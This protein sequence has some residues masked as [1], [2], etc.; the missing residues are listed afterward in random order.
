MSERS[1][2]ATAYA[3]LGL[4]SLK[5][6]QPLS[7]DEPGIGARPAGGLGFLA[8]FCISATQFDI[9][10]FDEPFY[11][12][13]HHLVRLGRSRVGHTL[14]A[15][16]RQGATAAAARL[17]KFCHTQG[18]SLSIGDTHG[19]HVLE[20]ALHDFDN[21]YGS[22]CL[23]GAVAVF[24]ALPR[25]VV[26]KRSNNP[27]LNLV[28]R[29]AID[30]R[31][32]PSIAWLL[33]VPSKLPAPLRA[34]CTAGTK[35]KRAPSLPKLVEIACSENHVALIEACIAQ[36]CFADSAS[37]CKALQQAIQSASPQVAEA[38]LAHGAFH[39]WPFPLTSRQLQDVFAAAAHKSLKSN[40]QYQHIC[41][42]LKALPLQAAR[43]SFRAALSKA[44]P[45]S[46]RV[47]QRLPT[48]SQ[49]CGTWCR[50]GHRLMVLRR[51]QR[52]AQAGGGRHIQGGPQAAAAPREAI[53]RST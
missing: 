14:H 11:G 50:P 30:E 22:E 52:R 36:G 37:R 5:A 35:G 42:N 16:V 43:D 29:K 47:L 21:S 6:W 8:D 26:L 10:A 49:W 24:D 38:L 48:E 45:K 39:G 15:C 4:D 9:D 23:C 13:V 34:A 2:I 44:S 31:H 28:A 20:C 40:L 1:A 3:A 25:D 12:P 32:I 27:F 7:F 51:V 46:L 18:S 17:A 33:S 41:A 53:S 19:M